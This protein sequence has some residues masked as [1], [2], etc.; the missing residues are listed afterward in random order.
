MKLK[1]RDELSEDD[2]R[3][4]E[5]ENRSWGLEDGVFFDGSRFRD[6]EGVSLPHHPSKSY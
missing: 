3:N 5:L 6:C 1:T 4:L 2:I